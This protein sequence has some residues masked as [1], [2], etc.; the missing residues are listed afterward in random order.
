ML[1][2]ISDFTK[3]PLRF[4]DLTTVAVFVKSEISHNKSTVFEPSDQLLCR[5]VLCRRVR[6]HK[7]TITGL[8]VGSSWCNWC[9]GL[10]LNRILGIPFLPSLVQRR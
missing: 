9:K 10:Y 7:A 8:L 4:F 6:R 3:K 5:R 2:E 1:C